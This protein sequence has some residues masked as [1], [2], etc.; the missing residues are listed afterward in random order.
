MGIRGDSLEK[1]A[2]SRESARRELTTA[3]PSLAVITPA[4]NDNSMA[5]GYTQLMPLSSEFYAML[6]SLFH[7]IA[8]TPD[9]PPVIPPQIG[10]LVP[11]SNW[12]LEDF[13]VALTALSQERQSQMEARQA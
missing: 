5:F 2:S 13:Q 4:Q 12:L 6:A 8:R 3:P 9:A 1:V 7:E 11:A 10:R